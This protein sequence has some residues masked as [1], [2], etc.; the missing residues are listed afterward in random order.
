MRENL[1][2]IMFTKLVLVVTAIAGLVCVIQTF[3]VPMPNPAAPPFSFGVN[4]WWDMSLAV[5]VGGSM[6]LTVLVRMP[7]KKA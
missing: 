1:E 5:L 3:F 6:I 4:W 7:K 2:K